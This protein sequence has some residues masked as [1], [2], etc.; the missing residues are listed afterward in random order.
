MLPVAEIIP[1]L[2]IILPVADI[3][4]VPSNDNDMKLVLEC[5]Y[6]AKTYNVDE[7]GTL[8]LYPDARVTGP[9]SKAFTFDATCTL[10]VSVFGPANV[11]YMVK[12]P[13]LI[14]TVFDCP[15]TLI[16]MLPEAT[17]IVIVVAPLAM[18]DADPALSPVKNA[19][20]PM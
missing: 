10:A 2:D 3:P 1:P 17:G 16:A 7:S 18:L 11:P 9:S 15:A 4:V 8:I 6:G 14:T 5:I 19:P 13:R 20:L 12:L